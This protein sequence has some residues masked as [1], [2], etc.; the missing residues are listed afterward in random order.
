MENPNFPT[1]RTFMRQSACA[2]V[3]MGAL[4]DQL[5]TMR[6]L[7]AAITAGNGEF[8]DYKALVC[9]F[10]Y[11]GNDANNLIVP[12]TGAEHAAYAGARGNL[13]IPQADL[14]TINPNNSDGRS[15]GFHPAMPELHSLFNSGD[16]ALLANVGTLLAPTTKA[17]YFSGSAALPPQLFSHADQQVQW[18]SNVSDTR[19]G[20]G[21]G[22]R[23]A[24]CLRESNSS[25]ISMSI[26]LA[27]TNTFQV[28]NDVLQYHVGVN[29]PIGLNQYQ[30]PDAPYPSDPRY[31][32]SRYIDNILNLAHGNLFEKQ[33]TDVQLRAMGNEKLLKD[34]LDQ[35]TLNTTF[36]QENHLARQLE[37]IARLIA[38]R[39]EI[40][41]KRQ[42]FFCAVG[43]YDTHG[44]QVEP[45]A[46]LLG[47]LSEAMSQFQSAMG[48]SDLNIADQVTS[49][50][51]SDFGRT[52][53][54]NGEGSDHG[55]GNHQIVMG[56]AVQGNKIYGNMPVLEVDG[57]DD[58]RT[59]RWIPS[60]S[61][62]EY[63]ATLAKWF[64]ISDLNAIYPN[65][66]RFGNPDIGFMM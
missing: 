39:D 50:T 27:G 48:S 36:N 19:S 2:A 37:M 33:Y 64:G 59:G 41:M 4:V 42:V 66:H 40:G 24:D 53:P 17:D 14:L 62:D 45:H 38:T 34:A 7:N 32:R 58:T 43:G 20:Q 3:G 11:G 47:E 44:D 30:H 31:Q 23:L 1:R 13:A 18:Q 63:S 9:I 56:G 57:P 60:T 52:F 49:F 10:L 25:E 35:V 28:G 65:L 12:A 61:V 16:A 6:T 8:D 55:W 46:N 54:T 51:A 26:S 21:W 15:W 29:G 5:L 22:G